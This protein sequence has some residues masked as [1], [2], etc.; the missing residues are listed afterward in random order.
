LD[1]LIPKVMQANTSAPSLE[2]AWKV[3]N[4][5]AK[6][7][8]DYTSKLPE[9][10]KAQVETGLNAYKEMRNGINTNIIAN[11]DEG[12]WSEDELNAMSLE[13]LQKL[14]KSV[15]K[16][17]DFSVQGV[18]SYKSSDGTVIAPMLPN[19]GTESDK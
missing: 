6:S 19:F 14:E 13:T 5:N 4:T 9:S 10:I 7:I 8:E 17:G 1:K 11:T 3:I 12:T 15:I 16:S 2:D 18:S